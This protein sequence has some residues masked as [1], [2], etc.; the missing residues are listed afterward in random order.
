MADF[1]STVLVCFQNRGYIAELYN[2]YLSCTH[3]G[4]LC[5]F[6]RVGAGDLPSTRQF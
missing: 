2:R 3:S 5:I 1:D 4:K 6:G